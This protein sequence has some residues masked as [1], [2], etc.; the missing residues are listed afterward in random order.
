MVK[1][2]IILQQKFCLHCLEELHQI[3]MEIFAVYTVF[4][5]TA[6]KMHIK[7]HESVCNDHDY[8]HAGMPNK[9][10]KILEYSHREKSLKVPDTIHFDIESL[11][12][13]YIF[14]KIIL[15]NLLQ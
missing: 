4:I 9:D 2:G 5:H 1:N 14:V 15:K 8:C 13:K 12:K 11:L 3:I 6:Q 7:K 10:N